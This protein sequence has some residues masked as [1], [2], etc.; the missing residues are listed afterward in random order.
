M[1]DANVF[2]KYHS[3][4][5]S[6]SGRLVIRQVKTRQKL[7]FSSYHRPTTTAERNLGGIQKIISYHTKGPFTQ[8]SGS[9]ILVVKLEGGVSI[10]SFPGG[11]RERCSTVIIWLVGIDLFP[12]E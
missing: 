2:I 3:V 4:G 7:Q 9:D 5:T 8:L 12:P 10:T 11:K 1:P 6:N